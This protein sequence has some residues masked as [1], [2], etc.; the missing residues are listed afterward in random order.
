MKKSHILNSF[1]LSIF[2]HTRIRTLFWILLFFWFLKTFKFKGH[3]FFRSSDLWKYFSALK[4]QNIWP[5]SNGENKCCIPYVFEFQSYVT[6]HHVYKDIWTTTLNEKLSTATEP[7]N[8][9][10]KYAVKV[11]KEN[12][13]IGH[14]PRDIHLRT[15]AWGDYKMWDYR[16]KTK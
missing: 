3:Q 6:E 13:V 15:F 7:Q 16:E 9:H 1:I 2:E 12:K 14:V 4:L 10:N 8:H 5:I 11:L